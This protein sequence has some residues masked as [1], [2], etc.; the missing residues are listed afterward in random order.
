[1][2]YT[3]E[4]IAKMRSDAAWLGLTLT[5]YLYMVERLTGRK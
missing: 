4:E 3:P 2:T 1:M 5:D